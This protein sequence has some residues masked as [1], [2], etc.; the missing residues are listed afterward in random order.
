MDTS[1]FTVLSGADADAC[2][3]VNLVCAIEQADARQPYFQRPA[4][5]QLK[6]CETAAL[7]TTP[8]GCLPELGAP[9]EA[10]LRRPS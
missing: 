4:T 1:P 10:S 7:R 8:G 9:S 3:V 6:R 5:T 2:A